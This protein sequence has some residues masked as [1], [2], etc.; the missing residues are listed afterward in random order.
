MEN[1]NTAPNTTKDGDVPNEEF[2]LN[3]APIRLDPV[4]MPGMLKVSNV[5]LKRG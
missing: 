2:S 1:F 5:T 3:F 4:R